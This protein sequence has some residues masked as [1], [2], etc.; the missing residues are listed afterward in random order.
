MKKGDWFAVEAID[1]GN[2][3]NLCTA[4]CVSHS[5]TILSIPKRELYLFPKEFEQE[6]REKNVEFHTK[7]KD[8]KDAFRLQYL[9]RIQTINNCNDN[10]T[11]TMR[12]ALS[13]QNI[14]QYN[15]RGSD[16]LLVERKNPRKHLHIETLRAETFG[17]LHVA[18]M[19]E[20]N[21]KKHHKNT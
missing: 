12:R 4:S 15:Q 1:D 14:L 7:V 17:P 9:E 11:K 3:M 21:R 13:M 8:A 18:A 5:A 2:P 6:I 19:N 20:I 16:K 10:S